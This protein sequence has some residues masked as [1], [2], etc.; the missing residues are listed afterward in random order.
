MADVQM[1]ISLPSAQVP[2]IIHALC[3]A[4]GRPESAPNAKQALL[5]WIK[6]TVRNIEQSEAEAAAAAGISVT[7]V[8]PA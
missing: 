6:A 5:D 4:G 2:R 1:T 3:A 8:T 7:P